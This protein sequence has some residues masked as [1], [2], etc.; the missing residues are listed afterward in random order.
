MKFLE[1]D[2]LKLR[3]LE[4]EDLEL[5]YL[6]ENDPTLWVAGNTRT[7]YSRFQLKQ[8]L[9]QSTFDIYENKQLRLMITEK[10]GNQ[11]VGTVDLFDFDLHHSR[12][13]VG[14]YVAA[15]F[16]GKGFASQSLKLA[17]KYVFNFLKINQIYA[18]VAENNLSSRKLFENNDYELSGTL[19]NW[20]KTP[21]GFESI[22]IYQKFN[23]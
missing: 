21:D 16:Q 3:A 1:N 11:T 13:T 19:K 6:W 8:Y 17:E 12:L 10:N 20:I 23:N 4:P 22:L 9:A 15:E 2:I 14:F 7:P 5:L 18:H